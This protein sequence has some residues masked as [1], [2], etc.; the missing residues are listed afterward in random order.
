MEGMKVC[1]ILGF[2]SGFEFLGSIAD[3]AL[4]HSLA[5]A[6]ALGGSICA[7]RLASL[8]SDNSRSPV[9]APKSPDESSPRPDAEPSA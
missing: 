1:L 2:I 4:G 7:L 6:L 9:S 3:F 5:G 8:R